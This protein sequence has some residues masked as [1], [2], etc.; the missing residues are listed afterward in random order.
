MFKLKFLLLTLSLF[1]LPTLPSQTCLPVHDNRTT[2]PTAT[3]TQRDFFACCTETYPSPKR[4]PI[5]SHILIHF[6]V[7][8]L[9]PF[10]LPPQMPL[11]KGVPLT[12]KSAPSARLSSSI[13]LFSASNHPS[14]LLKSL[15]ERSIPSHFQLKIPA[16]H[17]FPFLSTHVTTPNLP[18]SPSHPDN[19]C[20]SH[21]STARLFPL[22]H[23]NLSLAKK[24]PHPLP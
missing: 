14:Y 6:P 13:S 5:R 12:K 20:H 23:R 17:Y 18:T 4:R 8:S 21:P 22:L 15:E 7:F 16:P 9:Q 11:A 10:F 19:P 2:H 3:H 1:F 24:A